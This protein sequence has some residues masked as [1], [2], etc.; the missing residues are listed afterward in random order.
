ME[1]GIFQLCPNCLNCYDLHGPIF[2]LPADPLNEIYV[3]NVCGLVYKPILNYNKLVPS[4]VQYTKESWTKFRA[5]HQERLNKIARKT[6][7][8]E[9]I[10]SNDFILDVGA[11]IG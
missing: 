7:E 9:K 3:C 5:A 10:S 1:S 11:G 6:A 2:I 8:V 4:K